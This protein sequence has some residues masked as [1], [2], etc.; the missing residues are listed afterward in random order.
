MSLQ[1]QQKTL[2]SVNQSILNKVLKQEE[3]VKLK[4]ELLFVSEER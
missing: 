4:E 3:V 2:L 1:S